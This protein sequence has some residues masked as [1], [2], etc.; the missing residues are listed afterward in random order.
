[1]SASTMV[2]RPDFLIAVLLVAT[3]YGQA[4]GQNSTCPAGYYC[5][6]NNLSNQIICPEGYYCMQGSTAPTTCDFNWLLQYAPDTIIPSGEDNPITAAEAVYFQGQALAG[7]LCPK[8]S[9]TPTQSCPAGYY[10]PN[11]TTKIIC[12]DEHYCK[13]GSAAPWNCSFFSVC[14]AG[15]DSPRV[16]YTAVIGIVIILFAIYVGYVLIFLWVRVKRRRNTE[17]LEQ[18]EALVSAIAPLL[19]P[20]YDPKTNHLKLFSKVKPKVSIAF[21]EL[22]LTLKSGA[23]ILK[24]VTGEFKHSKLYAVMGP[25]GAGKSTFFNTLTGSAASYGTI[26][27]TVTING[28]EGVNLSAYKDVVGFVPQDDI[29][30]E[31]LTVRE[32]LAFAAYLK[33]D[34]KVSGQ[35]CQE[36]ADAVV[37]MLGMRHIAHSIVGSVTKRGISGGQRKRVNI[38]MELV[39]RPSVC[40]MDEPTSGLD[41][42][43]TLEVLSALKSLALCGMNI[44]AVIHQPRYSV[45][46]LFDELL[47]LAKGG[48]TAFMGP[49]E[50]M[51]EYFES[52]GFKMADNENPA[53]FMLDVCSGSIPRAND[54]NFKPSDLNGLWFEHGVQFVEARRSQAAEFEIS[55]SHLATESS[56]MMNERIHAIRAELL[57]MAK[58]KARNAHDPLPGDG[59]HTGSPVH[60]SGDLLGQY[61]LD[62]PEMKTF[63]ETLVQGQVEEEDVAAL[64][65]AVAPQNTG[66]V[67]AADILAF[68]V[69]GKYKEHLYRSSSIASRG[70]S[71]VPGAGPDIKSFVT[72]GDVEV[73][74]QEKDCLGNPVNRQGRST[75]FVFCVLVMRL[76]VKKARN[77]QDMIVNLLLMLITSSIAGLVSG[78]SYAPNQYLTNVNT[79]F[80]V[81]GMIMVVAS[82]NVFGSDRIIYIRETKAGIGTTALFTAVNVVHLIDVFLLPLIFTGMFYGFMQ[83]VCSFKWFYLSMLMCSWYSSGL[84]YVASVLFSPVNSVVAAA[85]Y[86]LIFNAF[87]NGVNTPS[88]VSSNGSQYRYLNGFGQFLAGLSYNR[89]VVE[90]VTIKEYEFYDYYLQPSTHYIMASVGLCGTSSYPS[91]Y[92]SRCTPEQ[93][94]Q[95]LSTV[96]LN[97][98]VTSNYCQPG[99]YMMWDFLAVLLLGAVYRLFAYIA[100]WMKLRPEVPGPY[101]ALKKLVEAGIDKAKSWGKKEKEP[102]AQE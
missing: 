16:T 49:T 47:L 26:T 44:S 86:A 84:A 31:D 62:L 19:G 38:G 63:L 6:N 74:I 99:D 24:N 54:P 42:T 20:K 39:A 33:L 10:C 77:W 53:D 95:T 69:T 35:E 67:A 15:S 28:Q 25:S 23:T 36:V 71:N 50:Q 51:L 57:H 3:L 78:A 18:R 83:P 88:A 100:L 32:N 2:V 97:D 14:D 70:G 93:Y 29:V 79:A 56:I 34:K 9:I 87:V 90:I 41:S 98:M 58:R 59:D 46:I 91:P 82:N 101:V 45:F 64:M 11:T 17:A 60:A 8:G 37:D 52:T 48:L 12:P 85:A 96:T 13:T 92:D 65:K 22:C 76:L 94:A 68:V 43:A 27:G 55:R 21:R 5:P 7:N 75:G 89:W 61:H 81:F 72:N 80:L 1:M 102:R 66:S 73:G 40:F 4:L 30:H